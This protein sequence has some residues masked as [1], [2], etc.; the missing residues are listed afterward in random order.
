MEYSKFGKKFTSN[1]GVLQ[2]MD[3]LGSA[4]NS[5]RKMIML[6]GGNPA[7]IPAV[8]S[9]MRQAMEELLATGDDFEQVIGNY[10]PPQGDYPFTVAL[11]ELLNQQ[12][13]WDVSARNI[14]LTNGSQ[15]TFFYLFNMLAGHFSD[16]SFKKVLFPLAPEYIG[17]LDAGLTEGLFIASKPE[18]QYLEDHLFKYRVDFNNVNITAD[19]GA[20]CVSRP[21]NPT[22][23]VLTDGEIEKLDKLARRHGI[24]LIVDNAYGIPFP[25]IIFSDAQPSWNENTILCMSLS[26]LGLPGVRT[27]IVVASE[28]VAAAMSAFNAVISLTPGSIGARLTRNLIK[29]GEVIRIGQKLIK[30]YYRQKAE[31]AVDELRRELRG[32]DFFIHKPEGAF[33]LWLWFRGLP[34][35]SQQL[36]ERLK[37]RGVIVVPGEY[38]FPGIDEPWDHKYECLRMSYAGEETDVREGIRIIAKE[39]KRAYD[40]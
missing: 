15:T 39:V 3:D 18:F 1:S 16:G 27:G 31:L 38:F 37:N 11:A 32:T 4:L 14:A 12:Y 20:I 9:V 25:G 30:P 35:T 26:K 24:P 36:Y 13:G 19:I 23:N 28:Q 7:K 22:G 21:T 34:L 6:G 8:Q 10:G 2:L 40:S 29:S 17:Y 5:D 33:F